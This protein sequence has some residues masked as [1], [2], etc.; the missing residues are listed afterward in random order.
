V[1]T[2]AVPLRYATQRPIAAISVATLASRLE[3]D[4]V[5]WIATLRVD[6]AR[7][8][9]AELAQLEPGSVS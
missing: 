3:K 9:E 1:R 6:C 4:R 8:I 2:I 5:A 7:E